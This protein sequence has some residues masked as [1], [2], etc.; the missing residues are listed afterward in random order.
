MGG[1][2]AGFTMGGEE[3]FEFLVVGKG[4][5]GAMPHQG[6]DPI[7]AASAVVQSLQVLVARETDPIGSSVVSV[8]IFQAGHAYSAI[9]DEV[10]LGGTLRALEVESLEILRLR[11]VEVITNVAKAHRCTVKGLKFSP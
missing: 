2:R 9:P 5:H 8:T 7:V 3:D 1:G 10:R 4:T 11:F 6:I